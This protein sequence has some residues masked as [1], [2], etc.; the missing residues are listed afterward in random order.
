VE[1]PYRREGNVEVAKIVEDIEEEKCNNFF[2]NNLQMEWRGFTGI[3][4][5][6]S[7]SKNKEVMI[8]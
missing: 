7:T 1:G 6:R 8:I 4:K 3:F 2:D 5:T